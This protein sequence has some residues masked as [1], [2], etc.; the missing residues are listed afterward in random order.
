MSKNSGHKENCRIMC[1]YSG[2]FNT[3]LDGN[4]KIFHGPAPAQHTLAGNCMEIEQD[5]YYGEM[6]T[7]FALLCSA[8]LTPRD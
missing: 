2:I 8:Q 1:K 3:Q 4:R 7:S 6:G 5:N